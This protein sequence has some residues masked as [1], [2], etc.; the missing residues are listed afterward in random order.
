[1]RILVVAALYPPDSRGGAENSAANLTRWLAR[2]GHEMAV[3]TTAGS[4]AEELHGVEVDGIRIWRLRTAHLYP[5]RDAPV[6]ALWKKPIWHLQDHVDP[7]NPRLVAKVIEAFRPDFVNVHFVQGIGYN[8]LTEIAGAG[9]PTLFLLHDL[10]LACMRMSMFRDG[11]NCARQCPGCRISSRYKAALIARFERI[12]FCSPSR[13]NLATL[14]ALFPIAR[15]PRI[16]IP[17]PNLYDRPD[18]PRRAS[19]LVR[20]LYVGRMHRSKGVELLLEAA[21]ALAATHRFQLTIV[22]GGPEAARLQGRYRPSAWLRFAGHVPE[23]AVSG[24]MRDADLLCVPSLW[25]ENW[26]GVAVRALELGLPVL[27]SRIGG[28]PELIDPGQTGDLVPAGDRAAWIAALRRVLENP[29]ELARWQRNAEATQG[30]F[31]QDRLGERMLAFMATIA[32]S[33]AAAT[34]VRED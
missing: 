12:G 27:G 32:G 24:Y 33:S 19:D 25:Q 16:S 31:D 6:A 26:P 18:L 13:T 28:L 29:M 9:L 14:S 8:A 3:L 11:A 30:R 2:Q 21:E 23:V 5:A 22:G 34:E 1:M 4:P 7:R 20:L 10:G 15:Y 17:N